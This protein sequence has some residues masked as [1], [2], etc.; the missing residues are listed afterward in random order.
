MKKIALA[1]LAALMSTQLSAGDVKPLVGLELGFEGGNLERTVGSTSKDF[2]YSGANFRLFGGISIPHETLESRIKLYFEGASGS[3]GYDSGDQDA[4]SDEIGLAYEL[5]IVQEG[6]EPYFAIELGSGNTQEDYAGAPE[7]DYASFGLYGGALFPVNENL[8]FSARLGYKVRAYD[9]YYTL[10]G[11][12][13]TVVE[14]TYSG[15]DLKFGLA[16]KF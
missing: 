4:N 8:E 9:D 13:P 2:D 12:T 14:N 15:F 11:F 7:Y 10:I 16:Y 5:V 6:I 3:I 1:S